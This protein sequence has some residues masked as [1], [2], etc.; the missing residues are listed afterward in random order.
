MRIAHAELTPIAL[1]DLRLANTKGTSV[2]LRAIIVITTGSGLTR[3]GE[4][5]GDVRTDRHAAGHETRGRR[6]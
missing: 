4:T 2:F 1:P 5:Y 3:L 6:I